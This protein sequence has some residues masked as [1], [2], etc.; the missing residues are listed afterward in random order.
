MRYA[1]MF[2]LL[3]F[4]TSDDPDD[5]SCSGHHYGDWKEVGRYAIRE[6]EDST[7]FYASAW[8]AYTEMRREC[9]H[10]GCDH[11]ERETFTVSCDDVKAESSAEHLNAAHRGGDGRVDDVSLFTSEDAARAALAG[12]ILK[13]CDEWSVKHESQLPTG[14]EAAGDGDE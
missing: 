9:V 13:G 8:R 6:V 5:E 3:S 7:V 11:S 10:E 14:W 12:Q 1:T 4:V 2:G